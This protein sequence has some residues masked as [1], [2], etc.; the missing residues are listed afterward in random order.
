MNKSSKTIIIVIAIIAV[1]AIMAGFYFLLPTNKKSVYS[2][3][4][5]KIGDIT[6]AVSVT[7]KVQSAQSFN[8]AF[9]GGGRV[10]KI[11]AQVNDQVKAGQILVS[12]E[13]GTYAAQLEQASANVQ[14]EQANL[15]ALK[16]G[17]RPEDIA[18]S[19]AQYDN[20]QQSLQ[21]VQNQAN[22]SLESAYRTAALAAQQATTIAKNSIMVLTNIQFAHFLNPGPDRN[23][24]LI[25]SAKQD[26]LV[27][28]LGA[29]GDSGKWSNLLITNLNGGAYGDAQAAAISLA[30]DKIDQS[31]SETIDALQKVKTAL[32]I[33]PL[34]ADVTDAEKLSL[35]SEKGN[36]AGA[37]VDATAKQ[38]A[39]AVQKSGNV[40][41]I[42]A[43]LTAYDNAKN[44]LALKKSGA[45]AEQITGQEAKLKAAQANV[46]GLN[47][48]LVK[49][50]I[51]API[52]GVITAQNAKIG[53]IMPPTVPVVSL[54]SL[55]NFEIQTYVSEADIAKIKVGQP[56]IISLDAYGNQTKFDATV[57]AVDPAETIANGFPTYKTTLQFVKEDERIKSGMTANVGISTATKLN[58][59][60]IPVSA[61][62]SKNNDKFVLVDTGQPS[63]D[64]RKI[65]TGLVG[66]NG[67][68]EVISGLGQGDRVVNFGQLN[69]NQ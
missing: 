62:I 25:A 30:N 24:D 17:A 5:V 42:A 10:A 35:A 60:I 38:Q 7:G 61:I 13:N 48:V 26:A 37:L 20:A 22:T 41:S 58:V 43:A 57:T 50:V 3:I 16:N 11:N 51:R 65:E 31:L 59:V 32:N 56:A 14:A 55:A 4:E 49:T 33:I 64:Q 2:F 47:A 12:L 36:I 29:P 6:Q 9:E 69:I 68:V 44:A 18:L 63:P 23:V 40:S 34:T 1:V 27:A 46:D 52:D 67:Q 45:T 66:D 21:D 39:I 28:L 54:I 53:E 19:Q 15:Q 8:L